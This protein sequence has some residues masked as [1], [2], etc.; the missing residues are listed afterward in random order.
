MGSC[1][2]VFMQGICSWACEDRILYYCHDGLP[3]C[4]VS[5]VV[6]RN[7]C[8]LSIHISKVS[9]NCSVNM[10][11]YLRDTY[12][13]LLTTSR[14]PLATVST[15]HSHIT[16][17]MPVY[18]YWM[19]GQRY[20]HF[21]EKYM[22]PYYPEIRTLVA[23]VHLCAISTI[24]N[25]ERIWRPW[26]HLWYAQFGTFLLLLLA[27]PCPMVAAVWFLDTRTTSN[28]GCSFIPSLRTPKGVLV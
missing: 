16:L 2:L 5:S 20:N 6:L 1:S 15:A 10:R 13:G 3:L 26:I 28:T 12:W 14:A 9:Y 21:Y 24:S 23:R 17:A 7:A 27:K 8:C 19:S 18:N 25:G 11:H 4:R 22:P